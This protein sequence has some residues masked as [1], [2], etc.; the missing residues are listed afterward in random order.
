M[1]EGLGLIEMVWASRSDLGVA[2]GH[3]TLK[4]S[5]PSTGIDTQWCASWVGVFFRER[6]RTHTQLRGIAEKK[7]VLDAN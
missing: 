3:G 5:A 4:P 6:A 2:L 1:T 7:Y